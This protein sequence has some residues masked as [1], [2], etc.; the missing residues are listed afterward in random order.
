MK[1][2]LKYSAML[3]FLLSQSWSCRV[4]SVRN[5]PS[6]PVEIPTSFSTQPT[7]VAQQ[8]PGVRWWFDFQ[9]DELNQLME[10][11]LARN[12]DLRRAWTRYEQAKSLTR[13]ASSALWPQVSADITASRARSAFNAG[14]FGF[15]SFTNNNFSTGLA[16]GYEVDL[17][18]KVGARIDAGKAQA[19]A[20]RFDFETIA[21]SVT[22]QAAELW[23]MH[24]ELTAQKSLLEEQLSLNKTWLEL[25]ELRFNKGMATIL[26]VFQQR[27]QVA[28][29]RA[30]IP[31]IEAN[32]EL[33]HHQ[34]SVFLGYAPKKKLNLQRVAL[35]SVP[36]FSIDAVPM[37]VLQRRPDVRAAQLRVLAADHSV[38]AAIADRFPSLTLSASTGF[39][40]IEVADLFSNWVWNLAAGLTGALFDGGR[41]AAEV[42]RTKEVLQDSLLAYGQT[43]LRALK[44]VEDALTKIRGQERFMKELDLQLKVAN[45]TLKEARA[46]YLSGLNDYLPVLASL[47]VVQRLERRRLTAI[48][49]QLSFHIQ[50]RRALGGT[51]ASNLQRDKTGMISN[52]PTKKERTND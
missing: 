29:I 46:R 50:L 5:N 4:H 28:A 8:D 32:L 41:R 1:R 16:A 20:T 18:G 14:D 7:Q 37:T 12:F 39:R 9:D 44:E 21:I 36:E 15:M 31:D 35:P 24:I 11:A 3:V 10:Q 38:G 52:T 27:Q 13:Q 51:W 47:E 2:M 42:D 19:R 26:D 49:Q 25:V 33:V 6:P 40:S 23:L 43:V 22:A 45:S 30:Q 17:W 34:L 48:H